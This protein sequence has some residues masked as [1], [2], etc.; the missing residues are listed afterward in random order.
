MI[1]FELLKQL[2]TRWKGLFSLLVCLSV[3]MGLLSMDDKGKVTFYEVAI[4]TVLA[5]VQS[6]LAAKSRYLRVY[7]DNRRLRIENSA[8][9]MENDLLRQ[10]GVQNHRLREMLGFRE[11]SKYRLIPG[12]IIAREPSR[13]VTNCLIN[14]GSSDSI[15][16]NMPVLTSKGIVGKTA[17][18][19]ENYSLV[20][21]LLDPNSKI[22]VMNHRSRIVGILESYQS[23]W[24]IAR[25][26]AHSDVIR[27]DTLVTSGLG[28][29]FPKGLYVGLVNLENLESNDIVQGVGVMPFQKFQRVEEVF[30]FLRADSWVVGGATP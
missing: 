4:V 29:V 11:T 3:S 24:L 23:G 27:G 7:G 17:K 20:Q 16:I 8:L 25:F 13:F 12:E 30:V 14:L 1:L 19:F 6:V 22:S 2:F 28:G 21:L 10:K 18:A 9:K 26:P 15:D 5:P